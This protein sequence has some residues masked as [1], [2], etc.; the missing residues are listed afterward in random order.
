MKTVLTFYG[1]M[2]AWNTSAQPGIDEMQ[3]AQLDLTANFFS[4]FDLSLVIAALLG[5]TGAGK[6]Y[7]NWQMGKDRI[8]SDVAAWFYAAFFMLLAGTFLKALFGI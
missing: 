6:I 8:D 5:L 7:Q 1:S 4:V 3:R 2:L